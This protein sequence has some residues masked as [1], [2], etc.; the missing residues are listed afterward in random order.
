MASNAAKNALTNNVLGIGQ[1]FSVPGKQ[2]VTS[3]SQALLGGMTGAPAISNPETTRQPVNPELTQVAVT[4]RDKNT[5]ETIK[6]YPNALAFQEDFRVVSGGA[7]SPA[8]VSASQIIP[9]AIGSVAEGATIGS[10][11]LGIPGAILG[12]AVGAISATEKVLQAQ[13]D[14]Y[15]EF[16]NDQERQI[17][18]PVVE[19]T[20]ERTGQTKYKIDSSKLAKGNELSGAFVK[21]LQSIPDG[22]PVSWSE[23]GS[24]NIN[25]APAFA[26]SEYYKDAL[27]L[28]AENY[29]GLTK[30]IDEANDGK[31]LQT[32][33][34][35][36]K[37][38][39]N[40]FFYT[41]QQAAAF[42][43][44]FP[45][46]SEESINIALKNQLA[47]YFSQEQYDEGLG[48]YP[49]VVF[50]NGERVDTT[51]ARVFDTIY[52]MGDDKVAKDNYMNNLFALL[53]D[54]TTSTDNKAIIQ[55]QINAIYGAAGST[56]TKYS[57]MLTKDLWDYIGQT[58]A[59]TGFSLN[60]ISTLFT[61]GESHGNLDYFL[62]D[63]ILATITA[64]GGT[65]VNVGTS[66]VT[67]NLLEKGMRGISKL[68]LAGVAK[69]GGETGIGNAASKALQLVS[70]TS[71]SPISWN[72]A[73]FATS[74]GYNVA[75]DLTYDAVKYNI[76]QQIGKEMDFWEEF[77]Q[78]FAMDVIF[79]YSQ[80]SFLRNRMDAEGISTWT[81]REAADFVSRGHVETSVDS[82]TGQK[83]DMLVGADNKTIIAVNTTEGG[84]FAS[85]DPTS[86][87]TAAGMALRKGE[88]STAY[89]VNQMARQKAN[90]HATNVLKNKV[91]NTI[92]KNTTDRY[93]DL[94]LLGYNA[95]GVTGNKLYIS[96]MSNAADSSRVLRETTKDFYEISGVKTTYK[97][98]TDNL[99]KL[100]GK[101]AK[102]EL[103][104]EYNNY[105]IAKY[106][107]S[108]VEQ[109]YGKDSDEYKTALAFEKKFIDG[110]DKNIAGQLDV[111]MKNM[112]DIS[113]AGLDFEV[114][115]ELV[116]LENAETMQVYEGFIPIYTNREAVAS[117][118]LLPRWRGTHRRSKDKDVLQSP[119][120][121]MPPLQS[122]NKYIN[123][124]IKN[125]A[126]NKQINEVVE[127]A[128]FF[129]GISLQS[130]IKQGETPETR[131]ESLEPV[132]IIT[133]YDVPTKDQ[134]A[135]K[136]VS[137]TEKSYKDAI[138]KILKDNYISGILEDYKIA[139][140]NLTRTT[141]YP[142]MVTKD[143]FT[144]PLSTKLVEED[145]GGPLYDDYD[146]T[147]LKETVQDILNPGYK[148]IG[149]N[150]VS[151][152]IQKRVNT[153]LDSLNKIYRGT[154]EKGQSRFGR[155]VMD[156]YLQFYAS[157]EDGYDTALIYADDKPENVVEK[158]VSQNR[159]L[160][161][162]THDGLFILQDILQN[163]PN[164]ELQ[165]ISKKLIDLPYGEDEVAVD[166]NAINDIARNSVK[167]EGVDYKIGQ[168]FVE[169]LQSYGLDGV[170]VRPVYFSNQETGKSG[171]RLVDVN[172]PTRYNEVILFG[173]LTKTKIK[174]NTQT[175]VQKKLKAELNKINK[176]FDTAIEGLIG[177]TEKINRLNELIKSE[178][179]KKRA[180]TETQ[181]IEGDPFLPARTGAYKQGMTREQLDE[182]FL[183]ELS[184]A[185]S[186]AVTQANARNQKMGRA[187]KSDIEPLVESTVAGIEEGLDEYDPGVVMGVITEAIQMATRFVPY[188]ENLVSWVKNNS[189]KYLEELSQGTSFEEG[190]TA[191]NLITR[192]RIEGK[193]KG[194]PITRYVN[195]LK[196]TLYISGDNKR[197]DEIA[198]SIATILN[199]PVSYN[200]QNALIRG[201][202]TVARGTAWLRRTNITGGNLFRVPSNLAH[203]TGRAMVTA[204]ITGAMSPNKLAQA[205]IDPNFYSKEQMELTYK[206][207]D[208]LWNNIQDTT[209]EQVVSALGRNDLREVERNLSRPT[210][211]SSKVIFSESK[212]R[213]TKEQLK[214]QFNL[215]VWDVKNIGKGGLTDLLSR[216]G[217]IAENYTRKKAATNQFLLTQMAGIQNGKSFEDATADAYEDAMW[218]GRNVTTDFS[219]KGTITSWLSQFT[220][221]SYSGYSSTAS[222]LESFLSDPIGVSSRLSMTI[223]FY[224]ASMAILLSDETSRKK[225]MNMTEYRRQNSILIPVDKDNVIALPIDDELA[226][227]LSPC[228]TFVEAL[229]TQEPITFWTVF[230]SFL[231][232]GSL[233]LSGFTEGDKFNFWRGI[234]TM[235]SNYL[236]AAITAIG[237]QATGRN[238]YYG[239]DIVADEDYLASIGKSA[240]TM[241]DFTTNSKN[242]AILYHIANF[243]N[244]PQWR[245]QHAFEFLGGDLGQYVL[246]WVDQAVS[247]GEQV[248][249]KD[250]LDT[251]KK[252]FLPATGTNATNQFYDGMAELKAEK[253]T[254]E[255]KLATKAKEIKKATGDEK[256]KLIEE[257][258]QLI[259]DFVVK[260]GSWAQQ[261]LTVFE[262]DGTLT[263]DQAT[264]FYYLF[265]FVDSDVGASFEEGSIGSY[266]AGLLQ[267]QSSNQ[268][269][270]LQAQAQN[271]AGFNVPAQVYKK[272]DGTFAIRDATGIQALKNDI[273]SK[274]MQAVAKLNKIISDNDLK[275]ELNAINDQISTIF[276]KNKLTSTDYDNIDKI[277]ANWDIKVAQYFAPV[278]QEYGVDIVTRSDVLDL[279]D[280]Y[281]LVIGD[282]EVD[283]R[284]R[285]ISAPNLNKQRGFAS[286]FIQEIY[287]KAGVK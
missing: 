55:S 216:P 135:I 96:K 242:S 235:A 154:L 20:D 122:L 81:S 110:V 70:S 186:E 111:I 253:K 97:T 251:L 158:D 109:D 180:Q 92:W 142:E 71:G 279:L 58:T 206:T 269:N 153:H 115:N 46:V 266:Y 151:P 102:K 192:E 189:N 245:V 284:G 11:A 99:I 42:E 131:L 15:Q 155:E 120:N 271:I 211:V 26:E 93:V 196:E 162:T 117:S 80:A 8:S 194:Y 30:E 261:Y 272:A 241:G 149:G 143:E 201:L 107:L 101:K 152:G 177:N 165:D 49:M 164:K 172:K 50:E 146:F 113:K 132:E 286:K 144:T 118:N 66:M 219:T 13:H 274:P 218:T 108:T 21:E 126:H 141:L 104:K 250:P 273:Y 255:T 32:F 106:R 29:S 137:D 2:T 129:D 19:Y 183:D 224:M 98:L 23:D 225:Y 150:T 125:A 166:Y 34:N 190:T 75:A 281:F 252:T 220:P 161:A 1:S 197:N 214:N 54:P 200:T 139:R 82:E 78:D 234:E 116:T 31:Y 254:V 188:Q 187:E 103:P 210:P 136:K 52:D 202:K 47:G 76:A 64:V 60:D 79:S 227:I 68:G 121:F 168:A 287:K 257:Q 175:E 203:D 39:Q 260:A 174:K 87:A 140:D 119:N 169:A 246:H 276:D 27:K 85:P 44:K 231:D 237:E 199:A 184:E 217:D 45:G 14:A 63:E 147:E 176:I 204:G 16:L 51:A 57:G 127:T 213:K 256:T 163:S 88:V 24:L 83:V 28:I 171:Q 232:M 4:V 25:V 9:T 248:G 215:I 247:S 94:K 239:S 182:Q 43:Q 56:D 59:V 265:D 267:Q 249:G 89:E 124:I 262:L 62:D 280:N 157:G 179:P 38:A 77:S 41:K 3:A 191:I 33:N 48:E 263:Q 12:G 156:S 268:A 72:G 36:L 5:G 212:S 283:K 17:E 173:D 207:I 159:I 258:R 181:T 105:M 40:N 128:Q 223:M 221:Y 270:Q 37:S 244:I 185:L 230:G 259:N 74:L 138:D 238:W 112:A 278:I 100:G 228:R 61:G 130:E 264:Q 275:K 226:G 285:Y 243:L 73:Q 282:Y 67:M 145:L 91:V 114:E 240:D 6:S 86:Y 133:R 18:M 170:T 236:P 205:F 229:S 277:R 22:D 69:L 134:K 10:K 222:F 35:A 208:R 198:K 148:G 123:N 90:T 53:S 65:A 178:H 195:G 7:T 84:E 233:D 167:A 95:A 193:P 209:E 160:D